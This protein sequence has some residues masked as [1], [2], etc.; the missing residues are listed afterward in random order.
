MGRSGL[1]VK[2]L[3]KKYGDRTLFSGVSF[4][5][6]AGSVVGVVRRAIWLLFFC[7][8]A[9]VQW[10]GTETL[11][12]HDCFWSWGGFGFRDALG[13]GG[14]WGRGHDAQTEHAEN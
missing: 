11:A 14:V 9:A 1:T 10:C 7:R 8:S 5:V 12:S 2:G 13:G 3:S 6:D 4:A